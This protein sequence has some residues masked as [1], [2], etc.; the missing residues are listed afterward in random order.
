MFKIHTKAQTWLA[1]HPPI[2]DRIAALQRMT[3]VLEG[4]RAA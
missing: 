4:R 1:T 2:N 3:N